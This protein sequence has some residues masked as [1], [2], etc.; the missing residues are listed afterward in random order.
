MPVNIV[1]WTFAAII[2]VT[3]SVSASAAADAV[4]YC[5]RL[6][7]SGYEHAVVLSKV[8]P[9]YPKN[10]LNRTGE[11]WVKFLATV[12]PEGVP[13]DI[14]VDDAVG[15]GT[16]IKISRDTLAKWRFAPARQ[17]DRRVF[18]Y[19]RRFAFEFRFDQEMGA[20]KEVV[21]L[22]YKRAR[23]FLIERDP[24]KAIEELD[25][26]LRFPMT[27]YERSMA[28]YLLALAHFQLQ[29]MDAA[30]LH[31]RHAL[32]HEGHYLEKGP[33]SEALALGVI[34]ESEAG[35]YIEALCDFQTLRKRDSAKAAEQETAELAADMIQLIDNQAPILIAAKISPA[36][37]EDTVPSWRHLLLRERFAFSQLPAEP[38]KFRLMCSFTL[39]ED[40]AVKNKIW[41]LPPG[42]RSCEI[43]VIGPVAAAFEFAE[44]R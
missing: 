38:L 18:E 12:S 21:I 24:K 35:N 27:I 29:D 7:S 37:A 39:V 17:A 43:R 16:F 1:R 44:I 15:G 25:F 40:V 34:L 6:K 20:Y 9:N 19:G 8:T 32:F 42:A 26:A 10:E 22:R 41:S 28:S 31:V 4:N 23:A 3:S 14:T 33:L 30:L 36:P 13:V 5:S 2:A 11:G